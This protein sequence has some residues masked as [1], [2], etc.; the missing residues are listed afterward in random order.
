MIRQCLHHETIKSIPTNTRCVVCG[1]DMIKCDAHSIM[2]TTERFD[3][4]ILQIK[5]NKNNVFLSSHNFCT[6]TPNLKLEMTIF[7]MLIE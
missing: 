1:P 2:N 5:L 4:I 3:V 7:I 6:S